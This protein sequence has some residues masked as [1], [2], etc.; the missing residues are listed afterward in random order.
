MSVEPRARAGRRLGAALVLILATAGCEEREAG[1][2]RPVVGDAAH[3]AIWISRE[4]CG[5]C[6]MIPGVMHA[7][8]LVGPPL[9]HFSKRT[10]VAGY[11]ANT[12]DNLVRWIQ[13]P[14]EVAPGNAMPDAGL[15]RQQARDI[16]AYLYTL[17]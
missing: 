4:G 9:E 6:H 14:Q 16:A 17:K 5:S 2:M 12:P 13:S 7:T 1:P 11:L 8:G 10:I 3:G 15:D